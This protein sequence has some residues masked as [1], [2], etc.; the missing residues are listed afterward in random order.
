MIMQ[1]ENKLSFFIALC[2][3][4]DCISFRLTYSNSR[5]RIKKLFDLFKKQKVKKNLMFDIKQYVL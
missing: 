3:K 1:T 2:M 4:K 5:E